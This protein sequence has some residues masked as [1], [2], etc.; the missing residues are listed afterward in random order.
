MAELFE[1]VELIV[2]GA[3]FAAEV[4]DTGLEPVTFWLP[5]ASGDKSFS[6]FSSVFTPPYGNQ[7]TIANRFV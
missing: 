5:D 4:E 3:P 6:A 1:V 7:P 2:D